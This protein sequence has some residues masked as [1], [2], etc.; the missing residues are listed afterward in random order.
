[1]KT[2]IWIM[3]HYASTMAQ[4]H[5]G[6]HLW[7]AK[8]LKKK[9]YDPII[10]CA[11]TIH[12]S[13]VTIDTQTNLFTEKV[14]DGIRFVFVKTVPYQE[15]GLSRIQ[16]MLVFAINLCKVAKNYR[17]PDIILASSVHPFT[18][19]AG[20]KIAKKFKVKCICEIRD[21][22]P[23]SLKVYGVLKEKSL[24]LNILYYGERWIYKH[25]DAIVFTMEGG[26]DYIKDRGWS[27]EISKNKIFNINNGIDLEE[28]DYNADHFQVDDDDLIDNSKF[29]IIYSGSI[30]KA[31][32]LK[33]IVN[34]AELAQNNKQQDF[35]FLIYGDGDEKDSL[36]KYC[37]YH[38]IDNIKFKGRIEKKYVPYILKKAD[39][40]VW[41][42]INNDILK[43]GGS[44]NKL[45]EYL[46][47]GKP[48][49]STN[50][51]N[52]NL[53][54]RYKAGIANKVGTSEKIYESL[55]HLKNMTLNERTEMGEN[56]RF[57]ATK[58]DFSA[59]T[60][61]LENILIGKV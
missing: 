34:T 52:Y 31:N 48:I 35:I 4:D 36:E 1:M 57:A 21:L 59:L 33:T 13:T 42:F 5:G 58:H 28:F 7:F 18:L 37:S 10:F 16:N 44:P 11:N 23:E 39:V 45:F 12:N 49:L 17:K 8:Y 41:H 30:R 55:I 20:E 19:I 60:Q 14:I 46:A 56:A 50:T 43:Y 54:M 15:N 24:L 38:H 22:W 3:N 61:Q 6:R 51:I 26:M 9:G 2:S 40:N 27:D 53:V 32:D 47:A 25:A 29:K